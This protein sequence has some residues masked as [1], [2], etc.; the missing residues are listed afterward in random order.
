MS[1]YR[2]PPPTRPATWLLSWRN[3]V[4]AFLTLQSLACS[5]Q[6][7]STAAEAAYG[8]AL[9]RCVDQARTLPES[10]ACRQRVDREWGIVQFAPDGGTP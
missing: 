9:L 3:V 1:P 5:R 10:K 6:H 2:D 4:F 8:A 7:A